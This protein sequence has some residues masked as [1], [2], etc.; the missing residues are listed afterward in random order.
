MLIK[1]QLN[2]KSVNNVGETY[3]Y[4]LCIVLKKYIQQ[5]VTTSNPNL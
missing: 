1:K 2:I 3:W 4:I 5:L